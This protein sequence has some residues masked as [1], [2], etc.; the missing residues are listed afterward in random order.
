MSILKYINTAAASK[1]RRKVCIKIIK[2]TNVGKLGGDIRKGKQS[3]VF[4][5]LYEIKLQHTFFIPLN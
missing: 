3:I 2:E 5:F 1:K 4:F